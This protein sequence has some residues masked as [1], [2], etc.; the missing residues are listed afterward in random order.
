[1]GRKRRFIDRFA[2]RKF[3]EAFLLLCGESN[4]V[5]TQRSTARIV[6]RFDFRGML[7]HNGVRVI[8]NPVHTYMRR[9]EMKKKRK[10]LSVGERLVLSV[11]NAGWSPGG[12]AK[13]PW[14]VYYDGRDISSCITTI[15]RPLPEQLGICVAIVVLE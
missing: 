9:P 3:G 2:S 8:L 5:Q 15:H 12:E 14:T 7:R 10:A 4:I 1:V 11:W 6:D 13:D